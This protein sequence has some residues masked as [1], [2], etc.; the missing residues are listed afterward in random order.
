MGRVPFGTPNSTS[1]DIFDLFRFTSPGTLLFQGGATAPAAYFSLDGGNTKL[2]DYGRTSDASD[3]LNTGVQGPNDP[4]NEFYTGGTSQ[5]LTA[6]DLK[7][8][9]A[10]GFHLMG[11]GT[12]VP[13]PAPL[14]VSQTGQMG[15]EWHIV[16]AA[17]FDGDGTAD[18]LWARGG[19]AA[20]WTMKNGTLSSFSASTQGHMGPEWTAVWASGDFNNDGR[21]DV[22]WTNPAAGSVA[23]WEMNGANLLA[24]GAPATSLGSSWHVGGIGDFD[25]DRKSDIL[26]VSDTNQVSVWSMNGTTVANMA[27]SN[28]HVGMEWSLG[29]IGD[30]AGN[31]RDGTIWVNSSGDLASWSMNG[32]TVTALTSAGHMGTAWHIAGV[33]DFNKDGTDDLVWVDAANDVEITFIN[34]NQVS[35]IVTTTGHM[36]PDWQLK[37]VADLTGDGGADLLWLRTNGTTSVWDMRGIS[38]SSA[39]A[40]TFNFDGLASQ[41]PANPLSDFSDANPHANQPAFHDAGSDQIDH[42]AH[43]DAIPAL[44][45]AHLLHGDLI[46]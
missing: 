45:L 17:D 27:T 42:A 24:F 23:I 14:L 10:L 40:D 21:S 36:G 3:F 41:Q 11:P 6:A 44:L 8:L 12:Q 16:T 28:G 25:G 37:G 13:S 2:A 31:G 34:G 29:A 32:A 18:I 38:G 4:F 1:P 35:Q 30:F 5:Q 15:S 19:D 9:V 46:V 7:Q 22:L 33:G 39:A 20:L 43:I 26:W